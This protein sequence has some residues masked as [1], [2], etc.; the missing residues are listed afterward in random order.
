MCRDLGLSIRLKTFK[1][2]IEKDA[3]SVNEGL[4]IS[5]MML[6]CHFVPLNYYVLDPDQC[7][8]LWILVITMSLTISFLTCIMVGISCNEMMAGTTKEF[9][10][11]WQL[12]LTMIGWG[13]GFISIDDHERE[14]GYV[15][16]NP[17]SEEQAIL[18]A[19]KD[20]EVPHDDDL[21]PQEELAILL[22]EAKTERL[23]EAIRAGQQDRLAAII[24]V[25]K[26]YELEE[27]LAFKIVGLPLTQELLVMILSLCASSLLAIFS[28]VVANFAKAQPVLLCHGL[29]GVA[30]AAAGNDAGNDG[31]PVDG[32]EDAAKV[33][34]IWGSGS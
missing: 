9:L 25:L 23:A 13:G 27:T 20:H 12:R 17:D 1:G 3:K 34:Q 22:K 15:P 7:V 30:A 4:G 33:S 10:H 31:S 28:S 5:F 21:S 18:A 32:V 8:P 6:V 2:E 24:A 11:T 26:H 14:W 19:R 29:I 16:Q